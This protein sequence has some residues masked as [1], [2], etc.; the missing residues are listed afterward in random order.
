M[1]VRTFRAQTINQALEL[2]K[3]ELGE[4]A[5]ILGNKKVSVS[6]EETWVEVTAAVDPNPPRAAHRKGFGAG[7]EGA[8]RGE[9]EGGPEPTASDALVPGLDA[10]AVQELQEIKGFLSLLISSKDYFHKL[11]MQEPVAEIYHSLIVRGLDEKHCYVLLK[12]AVS[13]LDPA[14]A[15]DR[16]RIAEAFCRQLLNRI[17]FA[18]P[19]QSLSPAGGLP[20][21]FTFVGPTGVGKTTSLAKLAAYLKIKRQLDVGIISVD[22]YRI[23]AVDQLRTYAGILDVSLEVVQD[24]EGFRLARERL[25]RRD[26]LLVDTSGKNFLHRKSIRDLQE[27]FADYD[28]INHFLVL[29]ATVKDG[30][31]RQTIAHFQPMNIH[32]FIFTKI[33]E[34]LSIGSIINQ[35]IRFSHPISYLGT[36]QQVPEDIELASPKRLLSFLLPARN[37]DNGKDD[38]GSGS[39]TA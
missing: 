9:K 8:E 12:D 18:R 31:L 37:D 39:G 21:T 38:N 26:V 2:V 6:P 36:G 28:D 35:L 1:Q 33:D 20:P 14:E 27:I 17:K 24:S 23:G 13:N 3:R 22:T 15:G 25:R 11:Q 7:E 5:L 4:D 34:T 30:D 19:F 16:F 32:S 10:R 29:S